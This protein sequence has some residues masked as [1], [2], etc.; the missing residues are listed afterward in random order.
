MQLQGIDHVALAVRDVERA[1]DWYV[2]VLGL[3]RLHAEEWKVPVFVGKGDTGI[4]LFPIEDAAGRKSPDERGSMLHLAFRTDG[5]GFT[6]AR[7][8]LNKRGIK[9]RFEDHGIAHSIYFSDPDG[10]NLEITTYEVGD[11]R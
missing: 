7:E 6:K 4:A 2:E 5:A 3:E 11:A 9:F 8:E 1:A 10:I